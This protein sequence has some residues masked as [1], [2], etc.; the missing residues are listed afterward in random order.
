MRS[1]YVYSPDGKLVAEYKG[2]D[3]VYYDSAYYDAQDTG[4]YVVP[5]IKEYRSM[6][7]GSV[8]TSRSQHCS[9]LKQHGCVEV[10]NDSSLRNPR[11]QP[12]KTP[13]G[14]KEEIIRVANEKLRR[15]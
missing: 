10:G 13:P 2:S 15:L 14:L 5:D 6:I 8:I 3:C 9:H 12:L 11:P 7:D 1:R 4:L